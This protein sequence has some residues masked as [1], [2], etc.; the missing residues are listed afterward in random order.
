MTNVV[1]RHFLMIVAP[2]AAATI[3]TADTFVVTTTAD[4]NDGSCDSHCSL[5]EAVI[6]TNQNI[7]FDQIDLPP[8]VYQLSILGADE[9]D[10]ASGD[11]DIKEDLY[12]RGS[13]RRTTII[14]A[15]GQAGLSDRVI[16]L[17]LGFSVTLESLMIKGGY[18]LIDGG[19]ISANG[20]NLTILRSVI[21]ENEALDDGGGLYK[22]GS[23]TLLVVDSVISGN[24]AGDNAGG[25]AAYGGQT[26]I[27]ASLVSENIA[28]DL[29]GGVAVAARLEMMSSTVDRNQ[30]G[31]DGGGVLLFG[32]GSASIMN[33][34]IS[35]NRA[36]DDGGGIAFSTGIMNLAAM[37]IINSTI[38]RNSALNNGGGA[39]TQFGSGLNLTN[40]TISQNTA[41]GFGSAVLNESR[42]GG[43]TQVN[44]IIDG[45][46]A[47]AGASLSNGGNIES[48]GDTCGFANPTDKANID[49]SNLLLGSLQHNGG[50]TETHA[51]GFGSVAVDM[52][53]NAE[54]P[55]GDQRGFSR[56]DGA[57]DAGAFEVGA[58]DPDS[59]DN[60]SLSEIPGLIVPGFEVDTT[61]PKGPTTF[62]AFR[63]TTDGTV[64]AAV[65]YYSDRV[66]EQ[67]LRLDSVTLQAR[68]TFTHNVRLDL[69]GLN[70]NENSA[71]GLIII[72]YLDPLTDLP[73]AKGLEGDYLRVDFGNDFASGDRLVRREKEFCFRQEIRFV[74]FGRSSQLRILIDRPQG[75]ALSSFSYTAY[76]E[77]GQMLATRDFLTSS[78]L[79][80]L[81]I[82]DLIAGA[83]FGTILFDFTNS[84]GGW[85]SGE[86]SA[87]GRFSL[88]LNAACRD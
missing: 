79:L 43:T 30:A 67:P 49:S 62:F 16:H 32:G 81:S 2:C 58:V 9:D 40:T 18:A 86:Y 4:V 56:V 80:V 70:I 64:S 59:S 23:G 17:P 51:L 33:S 42:G 66:S 72:Y 10:S 14:D 44:S 65:A 87:F 1:L 75:D 11:L 73:T 8:G 84:G 78:H 22:E 35:R 83:S 12:I 45:T 38:S 52:A 15:G 28:A 27:A 69:S 53:R 36:G 31:L 37:T 82:D 61:D 26:D 57:C 19:G 34:A 88:E 25:I 39:F 41:S 20:G 68:E 6:A 3:V 21:E 50:P 47:G 60:L 5:R 7:G 76:N 55:E 71:T 77:A 24:R 63:N 74:D 54:C 29:G 85:V 13:G 46:C 48:P